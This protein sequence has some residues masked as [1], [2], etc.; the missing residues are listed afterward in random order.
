MSR[1]LVIDD[2]EPIR[3]ILRV[4]LQRAGHEVV[5]AASGEE[6]LR[7]CRESAPDLVMTDIHLP[8]LD[9]IEV[10]LTLRALAPAVPVI[11]MSGGERTKRLDLLPSALQLGAVRVLRKPFTTRE[12]LDAV[13]A[14]LGR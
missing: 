11:V 9:G 14:V 6:G 8:G 13:G 7:C 1:V 4:L 3:R 2:E 12:V 10:A 5:L